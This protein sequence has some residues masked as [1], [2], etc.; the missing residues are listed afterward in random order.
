MTQRRIKLSILS[1][2]LI[3]CL[4]TFIFRWTNDVSV[5]SYPSFEFTSSNIPLLKATVKAEEITIT[6]TDT[7]NT[8]GTLEGDRTKN[9]QM[10]VMHRPVWKFDGNFIVQLEKLRIAAE[11]G[12]NEASYILA[13]NLRYCFNSPTDDIALEKKL[14]QAYEFSESELFVSRVTAKYEYCSGI[15]QKQ[16]NQFYTYSEAAANSGYVAAQEI[17]GRINPEFFMASQGYEDLERNEFIIMR[18]NF[19]EQKVAFL[20]RAAQNGSVEALARLSSMNRSQKI[21]GN[22]YVRY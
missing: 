7:P 5:A 4:T 20:K 14:D 21:R 13:M 15:E 9:G 11:N 10:V 6:S 1:V 22:G 12:N 2:L 19:I 16:R 18:D 8:N 17:I 3:I